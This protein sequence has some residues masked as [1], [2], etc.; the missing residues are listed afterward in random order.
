MSDELQK[1]ERV[2]EAVSCLNRAQELLEMEGL[3]EQLEIIGA[4]SPRHYTERLEQALEEAKRD[5]SGWQWA[6]AEYCKGMEYYRGLVEQIGQTIG[7]SAYIQD[8]GGKVDS[9]LCAKVPELVVKLKQEIK[10]AREEMFVFIR[11]WLEVAKMEDAL[12]K[13]G[14]DVNAAMAKARA[15]TLRSCARE[16]SNNLIKRLEGEIIWK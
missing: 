9:V 10:E 1:N 7:E 15:G 13:A 5:S 6:A 8:D 2:A 14:R 4:W 12:S 16:L 3:F 11:E